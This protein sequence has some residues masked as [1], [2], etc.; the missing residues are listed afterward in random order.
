MKIDGQNEIAAPPQAVW[1]AL[2]DPEVLKES[3]PGCESL[4]KVS[5]TELKATVLTK[6][7]PVRAKFN[8][9]V[10]LEDLNPPNSYTLSGRG[11]GGNAG[12][13]RGTARVRL[14]PVGSGTLL[15]YDIDAKVTGK[16]AQLG[17]RLILSTTKSMAGKF[18]DRF[19]EIVTA[20]AAGE[21]VPER[22]AAV[23]IVPMRWIWIALAGV[24]AAALLYWA[25]T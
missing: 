5:D 3:I 13:A 8:G 12:N 17:S 6:V 18:F 16:L 21:A 24:V 2:N 22:P 9:E 14:E 11:S 10:K 4:E 20:E 15:T 7:G 25:S 1:K 19:E 23:E